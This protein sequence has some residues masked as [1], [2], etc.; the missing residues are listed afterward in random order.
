VHQACNTAYVR[1]ANFGKMLPGRATGGVASPASPLQVLPGLVA[2][3]FVG[4]FN[5]LAVVDLGAG[6]WLNGIPPPNRAA[7]SAVEPPHANHR[8]DAQRL[9]VLWTKL[10][11]NNFRCL[12]GLTSPPTPAS[13]RT[14]DPVRSTAASVR[15]AP[16]ELAVTYCDEFA[17]HE[18][19]LAGLAPGELVELG[20]VEMCARENS[21]LL[22]QPITVPNMVQG[23]PQR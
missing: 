22:P 23:A 17:C 9:L 20:E 10:N 14:G 2:D 6:A 19:D 5:E 13:A 4:A 8:L 12:P 15:A 3:G 1:R 16:P 7:R 21:A 18:F 11:G